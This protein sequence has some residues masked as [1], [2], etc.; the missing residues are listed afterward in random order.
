MVSLVILC[1]LGWTCA[2][3]VSTQV[4]KPRATLVP[5]YESTFAADTDSNSPAIWDAVDGRPVLFVLNS[6]SG[7]PRLTAGRAVTRLNDVAPV[8]WATAAPLG[9]TWMEAVQ[10]DEGGTWY[11]YYHN[12]LQGTVCT[13]SE[14]VIARIGTARSIDRGRTWDDLGPMLE[15]RIADVR[16]ITNNHY[17]HGGVGDLSVALDRD[18]QFLYLFYTQ[19]IERRGAMGVSVARM[20]W[21]ARD[22]PAGAVDVWQAGAWLPS[23]WVPGEPNASDDD[24]APE[25][26]WEYPAATPVHVSTNTWDDKLGGVDVPW[27]PSVHWNTY[28]EQWVMLFNRANSNEWAQEGIYISFNPSIDRPDEWSAPERL[29]EGGLWYPQVVG[30]EPGR[31][32]DKEAGEVARFYM[33]GVSSHT[34]RFSR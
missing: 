28:L 9:G 15:G 26:R 24:A 7:W 22:E 14:K 34:I 4:T 13:D 21:A 12:E 16:C 6:H 23:S 8:T 30:T 18:H 19:Y 33:G 2:A 11:G 3:V 1:G 10:A 29:L 31:G 5:A 25:G 27:G 17:F 20:S 32:T